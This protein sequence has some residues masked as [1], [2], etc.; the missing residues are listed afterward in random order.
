MKITSFKKI[1]DSVWFKICKVLLIFVASAGLVFAMFRTS[2]QAEWSFVDDQEIAYYLGSDHKIE[3]PEAWHIYFNETEIGKYGSYARFRPAYFACRIL[4][5]W[6]W[7]D[8]LLFW[9]LTNLGIFTVFLGIFWY[10]LAEK[11]GFLI[12][13]LI[14]F[15]LAT[16]TYWIDIFVRLGPSEPYAVFGLALFGL[17]V[18]LLYYPWNLSMSWFLICMG[19]M[20]M[21]GSKENLFPILILLAFIVFDRF[22]KNQVNAW[23]WLWLA[24]TALWNVWILSSI[25]IAI[26][27][28]GRDFYQKSVSVADRSWILLAALRRWEVIALIGLCL[29]FLILGTLTRKRDRQ[30]SI[31]SITVGAS[32]SLLLSVYLT[33]FIIYGGDFPNGDRYDFPGLLVG[34]LT[35]GLLIW[36]FQRVPRLAKFRAYQ[37]VVF[38]IALLTS[39][40]LAY[41][42]V[43]G[44]KRAQRESRKYVRATHEFTQ[45][46]AKL[47]SL[48]EQYPDYTLIFQANT[49]INDFL[50]AFIYNPFLRY[51]G[52]SNSMSVLWA[53]P[54]PETYGEADAAFIHD[55]QKASL[56]GGTALTNVS[57]KPDFVPL[58]QTNGQNC[59]LLLL[60]SDKPAKDCLIV[61]R[62]NQ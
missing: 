16:S 20:I 43:D 56:Y 18:Y 47:Q 51:Y 13:G 61:H 35:V 38:V 53:G 4:E 44:I 3:L 46:V 21:T 15:F 60:S 50:F 55:L 7:G 34:P 30:F 39:A 12:G 62:W 41:S 42:H 52:V 9:Y 28:T 14:T 37:V 24:L 17:G 59:V 31:L 48:V 2:L 22:K 36:Y 49:P 32:L 40:A 54:P 25:L 1:N 11:I 10:L 23:G 8:N 6:I 19:T 58:S 27:K 45:D 29:V 33:Q 5:S 26:G 57:L